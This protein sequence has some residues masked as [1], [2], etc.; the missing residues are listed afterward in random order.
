MPE[1][2]EVQTIVDDLIAAGLIGRKITGADVFWPRT[3]ATP[4]PREF[5][6]ALQGQTIAGL[7]R[8]AKFIV[9]DLAHGGHLVIHLRMSGRLDWVASHEERDRHEHVIVR[10]AG[11]WQLRFHDSRKF[12]RFYLVPRTDELFAGLGPEPLEAGFT[13]THLGKLLATRKR[14]LKP[15]LLDQ[16]FIAGLGNIYA[17]EA[18]WD[19]RIH[20]RR[21]AASLERR[22]VTAL[23][24]AIRKVLQRG[25]ANLGTT[26]GT[27]AANF[28]SVGKHAGRNRDGLRVFRRTGNPCPRCR[29]PIDRIVVAQRS[30]HICPGCQS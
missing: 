7:W 21:E 3:I 24:R 2:P 13:A 30:T 15:L 14:Q 1:L 26:L 22:E 9:F 23:H 6:R 27:G 4:S 12:G 19:A 10:F 11:G 5:Q 20:P 29:T 25:L 28:Y 16:G 17:D 8:R 18:L